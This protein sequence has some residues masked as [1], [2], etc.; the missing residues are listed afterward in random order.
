MTVSLDIEKSLEFGL[1]LA[2]NRFGFSKE[3]QTQCTMSTRDLDMSCPVPLSKGSSLYYLGLAPGSV[4]E[5]HGMFD[6][7]P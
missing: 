6:Y 7:P 5:V 1:M 4:I 3:R 2:S